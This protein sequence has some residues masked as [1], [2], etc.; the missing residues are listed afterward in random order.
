MWDMIGPSF[1]HSHVLNR[2][3]SCLFSLI[4]FGTYVLYAFIGF[5]LWK[6][7]KWSLRAVVIVQWLGIVAAV[8]TA[9]AFAKA[10]G[11]LAISVGIFALAPCGAILWYL[12]QASVRYAFETGGSPSEV[13]ILNAL[14]PPPKPQ[15]SL[16]TKIAVFVTVGVVAIGVFAGGLF[17][18][19]EKMFRSSE[20][21][22]SALARA[23]DSPCIVGELGSP[24]IEK[25][26]IS[27]SISESRTDGSADMEIPV[28]GPR[29]GGELDVS[30]TEAGGTWTTTSLDLI[31]D[32]GQIHLLPVASPCQ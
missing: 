11:V 2:I 25:G 31:Y 18:S 15:H 28:R 9:I 6:L 21:Y 30:A 22:R 26:M 32:A 4:W 5:G 19:V 23:Q 29:G 10:Q 8:I 17:Y 7:R 24:V 14:P 3:A 13:S 20:P 12:N 16:R 1:I 27:G